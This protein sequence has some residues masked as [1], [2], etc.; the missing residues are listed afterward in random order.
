M[1]ELSAESLVPRDRV[2]DRHPVPLLHE[3]LGVA[4]MDWGAPRLLQ[5]SGGMLRDPVSPGDGE[6]G[7]VRWGKEWGVVLEGEA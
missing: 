7:A 6:G 1:G 4:C 3:A 5:A 2:N